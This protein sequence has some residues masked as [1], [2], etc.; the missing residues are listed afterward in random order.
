MTIVPCTHDFMKQAEMLVQS[1]FPWMSPLERLSFIAI[2]HPDS[3]LGRFL[4]QVG[5][6]KDV[7]TF[8]VYLDE[9]NTVRGTTGLYRYEKDAHE[10]VWLA[11]FCVDSAVRGRGIGQALIDHTVER[12]C[13]AGFAKIRLYT[14]TDPNEAAAQRLYQRNGFKEIRRKKGLF[15]TIVFR[16][17]KISEAEETDSTNTSSAHDC[18]LEA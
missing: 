10:A 13:N 7:V 18:R 9:T 8:D 11:W 15:T 4:R 17:R 16:E 6:I 5:G 14:S 3:F 12:A 2:K 1:V